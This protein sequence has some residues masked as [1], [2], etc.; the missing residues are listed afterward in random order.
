VIEAA[1]RACGFS[2]EKDDLRAT[3]AGT[4]G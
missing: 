1:A 2:T 3:F 4:L